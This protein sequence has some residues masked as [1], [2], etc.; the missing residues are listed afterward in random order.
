VILWPRSFK[1]YTADSLIGLKFSKA[2]GW[3]T[4]DPDNAAHLACF[5]DDTISAAAPAEDADYYY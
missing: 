4:Y 5:L 1:N 3:N 2:I